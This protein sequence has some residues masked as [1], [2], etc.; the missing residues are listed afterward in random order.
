MKWNEENL[1]IPHPTTLRGDS[2]AQKFVLRQKLSSESKIPLFFTYA[3]DIW[4]PSIW[5][6][7]VDIV[8]M[9]S[10][11][12]QNTLGD[13]VTSYNVDKDLLIW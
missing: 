8:W 10:Q 13:V 12:R 7:F 4:V 1:A 6:C 11:S 2:P 3:Y 5:A 9:D